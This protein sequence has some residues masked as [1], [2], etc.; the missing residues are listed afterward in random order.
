MISSGF[1]RRWKCHA[2]P[3]GGENVMLFGI[4]VIAF[5]ASPRQG[6]KASR[7]IRLPGFSCFTFQV[8]LHCS[9]THCWSFPVTRFSSSPR[10]DVRLATWKEA[11]FIPVCNRASAEGLQLTGK[12]W[13]KGESKGLQ[14]YAFTVSHRTTDTDM[15]RGQG[16]NTAAKFLCISYCCKLFPSN[17][18]FQTSNHVF[19]SVFSACFIF[20]PVDFHWPSFPTWVFRRGHGLGDH[21]MITVLPTE[22]WLSK[23]RGQVWWYGRYLHF[24]HFKII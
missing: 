2:M 14:L 15:Q 21:G 6:I 10:H 24:F 9:T 7:Q 23:Q 16:W 11:V 12:W 20:F 17:Q 4:K 5:I 18:F 8:L 1:S 19:P 13:S 22:A 3:G